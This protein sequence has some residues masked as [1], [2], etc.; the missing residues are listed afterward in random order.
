MTTQQKIIKNKVELLELAKHLGNVSKACQ[1]MG[2]SRGSFYRLKELYETWGRGRLGRDF[3]AHKP[4]LKNR[5]VPE[6]EARLVELT[7]GQSAWGQVR[8]ANGLRK[9]GVT[10]SSAGIRYIWLL[11]ELEPMFKSLLI[12]H[13]QWS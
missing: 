2:Y 7:I 1:I 9:E 8:M 4:L 11:H 5:E 3:P 10:L 12:S 6:V 13:H